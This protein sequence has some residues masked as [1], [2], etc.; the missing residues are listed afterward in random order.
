MKRL[1]FRLPPINVQSIS[2][3]VLFAGLF[4]SLTSY[5]NA[6][7][8]ATVPELRGLSFNPTSVNVSTVEQAITGTVRVTD[9]LSGFSNARIQ[10]RG[11]SNYYFTFYVEFNSTNRISGDD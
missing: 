2:T 6:Q 4:L 1:F 3:A 11:P 9:N 5:I 7:S 10:F 8:Y